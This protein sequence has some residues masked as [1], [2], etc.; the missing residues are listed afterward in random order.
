MKTGNGD[1]VWRLGM[2]LGV[3]TAC[4]DGDWEWRLGIQ[5]VNREWEIET[6]NREWEWR[7][8]VETGNRDWE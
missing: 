1:W 3:E 8:G 4:G 6:E 2:E 7:L 5:T